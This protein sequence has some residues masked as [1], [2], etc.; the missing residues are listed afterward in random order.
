MDSKW[1]HKY[2]IRLIQDTDTKFVVPIG[3]ILTPPK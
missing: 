1:Y 2:S 3:F